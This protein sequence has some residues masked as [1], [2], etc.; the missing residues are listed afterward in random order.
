MVQWGSRL[1]FSTSLIKESAYNGRMMALL[2]LSLGDCVVL[3]STS[4]KNIT[5]LKCYCKLHFAINKFDGVDIFMEI[6]SLWPECDRVAVRTI[7]P[8]CGQLLTQLSESSQTGSISTSNLQKDHGIQAIT[9]SW[10]INFSD[11]SE[12]LNKSWEWERWDVSEREVV[13]TD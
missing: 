7:K 3:C 5:S 8:E 13:L 2:S 1:H 6:V 12:W 11:L 9:E 10:R 4:K